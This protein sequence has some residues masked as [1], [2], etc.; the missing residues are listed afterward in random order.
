MILRSASMSI[1]KR[2]TLRTLCS[3]RDWRWI[4]EKRY[5]VRIDEASSALFQDVDEDFQDKYYQEYLDIM[6]L[7]VVVKRP[8]G[9]PGER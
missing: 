9:V 2:L 1:L 5:E 7:G 8:G 3:G 6:A 4:W